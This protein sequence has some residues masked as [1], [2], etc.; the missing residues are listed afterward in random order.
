MKKLI[1]AAV[2]AML[3]GMNVSRSFAEEVGVEVSTTSVEAMTIEATYRFLVPY[4]QSVEEL[5]EQGNYGL[6][7]P[8]INSENFP[9]KSTGT[10]EVEI[11]V[12]R[13]NKPM[14]RE[15][16]LAELDK[17]SRKCTGAHELLTFGKKRPS[18]QLK[19]RIFA[20]NSA[21][22][23]YGHD[24]FPNL[25]S[26]GS[27]RGVTLSWFADGLYEKDYRILAVRK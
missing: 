20:L 14:N 15:G 23:R 10:V 1:L 7:H 6:T 21:W 27:D 4:G 25:Y 22:Q 11:D 19:H 2:A 18:D 13:L 16:I 26:Y 17:L 9:N 8:Q 5:M 24:Y 3:F 12:V